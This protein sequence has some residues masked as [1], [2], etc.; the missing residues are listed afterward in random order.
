MQLSSGTEII[1]V[2]PGS[3]IK[4]NGKEGRFTGFDAQKKVTG[5]S[6]VGSDH[7]KYFNLEEINKIQLLKKGWIFSNMIYQSGMGF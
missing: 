7:V 2:K 4:L 3:I 5:F 1:K 6:A